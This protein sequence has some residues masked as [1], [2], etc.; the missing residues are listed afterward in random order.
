MQ[1]TQ[2]IQNM[3]GTRVMEDTGYPPDARS[4]EVLRA[5]PGVRDVAVVRVRLGDGDVGIAVVELSEFH[6]ATA[7]REYVAGTLGSEAG[8]EGVVVVD[9]L[10]R[11]A[12]G[13]AL[14]E[15]RA[16]AGAGAAAAVFAEPANELEAE[17]RALWLRCLPVPRVGATDDFLDLGG[18][19]IAAL[20]LVAELENAFG[21]GLDVFDLMDAATVRAQADLLAAR[22]VVA[23]GA[24][25]AVAAAWREAF[26]RED[27][28]P[29]DDFF[30][31]G[32][33][34]MHAAHISAI[35]TETRDA[36]VGMGLVIEN[37]TVRRQAAAL[38]GPVA[39]EG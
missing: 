9:A 13:P 38:A 7:L 15:V 16:L 4:A 37:R 36:P 18:D 8:V 31:I 14:D 22:G 20:A 3:Q 21:V 30:E 32:G 25:E 27:V 26:A 6:T 33:N 5:H 24:L 19:S 29:D 17:V 23:A 35:L 39:V 2:N 12:D 1:D 11:D 10:P 34:S 28:G